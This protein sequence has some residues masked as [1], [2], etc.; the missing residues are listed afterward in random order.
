MRE[1]SSTVLIKDKPAKGWEE[2]PQPT[3][4]TGGPWKLHGPVSA[5]Q[6]MQDPAQLLA[7]SSERILTSTRG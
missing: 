3:G 1:I 4:S 6:D 2:T 7:G 5:Q